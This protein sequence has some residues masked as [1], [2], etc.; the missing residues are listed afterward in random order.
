VAAHAFAECCHGTATSTVTPINT[1]T[2][3]C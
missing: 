1:N 2:Q 3:N